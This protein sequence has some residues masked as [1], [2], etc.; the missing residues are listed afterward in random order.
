MRTP[1]TYNDAIEKIGAAVS[2][3]TGGKR[4]D[5]VGFGVAG[6]LD[7]TG[8]M[9]K[10]GKLTEYG[11]VGKN[12]VLDIAE[13]LGVDPANV[14]G[15]NDVKAAAKGEQTVRN[16]R[17]DPY[18]LEALY[19][20][21]TGLGGA[22]YRPDEIIPDEPGHEFLRAGAVCGCGYDGCLEAHVSGSGIERKY[23]MRGEKIPRTDPTWDAVRSDLVE[24]FSGML[25]RYETTFGESPTRLSFYGSVALKGPQ[26]LE[27]LQTGLQE[28]HGPNTPEIS[29]A[30]F[31]DNSGLHGAYFMAQETLA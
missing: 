7:N 24:G 3:L 16:K 18:S 21:S 9:A 31:G 4:P 8:V 27:G 14:A 11:W 23:G 29:A 1:D 12:V 15:A 20:I 22:L 5:A 2:S 28:I 26:I 25:A 13:V 17:P 6:Q 19:T 30:A 10:A